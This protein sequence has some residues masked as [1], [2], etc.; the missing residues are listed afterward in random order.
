MILRM[1]FIENETTCKLGWFTLF[2]F[3]LTMF[4]FSGFDRIYEIQL[5]EIFFRFIQICRGKFVDFVL[6]FK[7]NDVIRVSPMN[8]FWNLLRDSGFSFI[9]MRFDF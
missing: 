4:F 1:S 9:L 6:F 7:Q 2:L 3:K 5:S 8:T